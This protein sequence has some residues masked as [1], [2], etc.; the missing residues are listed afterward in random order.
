MNREFTEAVNLLKQYRELTTAEE[1]KQADELIQ[2][3]LGA[4]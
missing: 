2:K 1:Q 4:I 3:L